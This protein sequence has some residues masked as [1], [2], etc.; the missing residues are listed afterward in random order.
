MWPEPLHLAGPIHLSLYGVLVAAGAFLGLISLR[1]TAP[2]V[3]WSPQA[4]GDLGFWL[5]VFG[6]IGARLFYVICHWSEFR[7]HPVTIFFYWKGGLMFQGAV[8]AAALTAIVV[9]RAQ[10]LGFWAPAD[11]VGPPLAL[12]QAVGRLGCY[13]AGCCYGRPAPADFPLAAVF[14]PGSVAP[15]RFPLYPTQLMEG[16]GLLLL[17][18]GL[19]L[20]LKKSPPPGRVFGAYLLGAGAL[21]ASLEQWRGDFRGPEFLSQA[22]T[23]WLAL[24]LAAVGLWA[25]CRPRPGQSL[26]LAKSR[27]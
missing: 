5:I 13:A 20:F 24:A 7:A 22:P 17:A 15:A 18:L 9:L 25:L 16:L 1:R 14:P 2:R 11:A 10:G 21:R 19:W 26:T 6:L 3:G 27:P 12:G 23:F 8:V 4:A